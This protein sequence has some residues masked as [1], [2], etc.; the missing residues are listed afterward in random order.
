[1]KKMVDKVDLDRMT[2]TFTIESNGETHMVVLA[3]WDI[4][5]IEAEANEAE[6]Q[7]KLM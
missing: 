4:E 3:P 6:K 1:M 7:D 2:R 5:A